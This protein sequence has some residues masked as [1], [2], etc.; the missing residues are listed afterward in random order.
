MLGSDF[1]QKWME[2]WFLILA[3]AGVIIALAV[4]KNLIS[5]IV[6]FFSGMFA[7]RLI[8]DRKDKMKFPYIMIIVAFLIGYLIGG[9]GTNRIIMILLFVLGIVFCYKLYDKKILKDTRY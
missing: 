9:V 2:F 1:Y 7:G 4:P 3:V 5:Y 8:Y 6:I